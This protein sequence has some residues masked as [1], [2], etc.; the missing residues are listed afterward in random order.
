MKNRA[1][2]AVVEVSFILFLFYAN[3]VMGEYTHSGPARNHGLMWAIRDAITRT[4]LAI[5]IAAALVGY[6]LF[7]SLRNR[8]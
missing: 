6:V 2:R 1:L 4:N 8:L 5:G 3:I 7:E